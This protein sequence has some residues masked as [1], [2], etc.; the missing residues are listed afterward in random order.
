[1][2]TNHIISESREN[3]SESIFVPCFRSH[4][5]LKV[6]ISYL[7]YR[8]LQWKCIKGEWEKNI[9]YAEPT[10]TGCREGW[11]RTSRAALG[12][13]THITCREVFPFTAHLQ[14]QQRGSWL[15][16]SHLLL[17]D[18]LLFLWNTQ[19]HHPVCYNFCLHV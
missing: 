15:E 12:N 1:M 9:F 6:C 5:L 16:T 10:N 18:H 19:T 11:Q 14:S 3:R 8:I 2:C 13:P 17:L 7:M 4:Y